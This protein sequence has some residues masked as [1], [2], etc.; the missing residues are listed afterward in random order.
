MSTTWERRHEA[1]KAI[2]DKIAEVLA[3][4]DDLTDPQT[5]EIVTS[6]SLKTVTIDHGTMGDNVIVAAV[7]GKRIKVYAVVLVV[8]AAVNCRWKSG[9]NDLS[10]DMNYNGKGEGYAQAVEP[11]DFLMATNAG[12][13]LVLNLSAAVPVDGIVSYWDS[14]AT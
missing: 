14:D 6:R 5:T 11:P 9:A 7:S 4:L 3:K 8:S 10:G 1:L 13:A 12:E 2:H